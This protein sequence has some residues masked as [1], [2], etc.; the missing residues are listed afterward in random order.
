MAIW[1]I[2]QQWGRCPKRSGATYEIGSEAPNRL[3]STATVVRCHDQASTPWSSLLRS[4]PIR[5]CDNR[6]YRG[7]WGREDAPEP[8]KPY[9]HL[10]SKHKSSDVFGTLLIRTT[11]PSPTPVQRGALSYRKR[12][13]TGIV[14]TQLNGTPSK[15]DIYLATSTETLT[16]KSF[17]AAAPGHPLICRLRKQNNDVAEYRTRTTC[18]P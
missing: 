5:A 1:P 17:S 15:H 7:P 13:R 14:H 4:T 16:A 3:T 9:S 12:I 10:L 8:D 2:W 6:R 18:R 11:N